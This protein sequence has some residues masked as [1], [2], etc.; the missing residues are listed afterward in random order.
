M[1]KQ[2]KVN[3]GLPLR[4][5]MCDTCPFRKG[6]PYAYLLQE[7]QISALTEA[8][9]ICHTTGENALFQTH[10]PEALCRGAREAQ[11]NYFHQIGFLESP[12]DE[13]WNRKFDEI[14][15]AR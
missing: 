14:H 9:R 12:T 15:A 1:S 10:Q 8:S 4:K 11:L 5:L 6:S 2:S 3:A 13:A 7:L